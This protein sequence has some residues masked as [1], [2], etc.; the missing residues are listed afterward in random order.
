M[1]SNLVVPL[2]NGRATI[3]KYRVEWDGSSGVPEQND[4]TT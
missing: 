3:K 2:N 4:I 1:K